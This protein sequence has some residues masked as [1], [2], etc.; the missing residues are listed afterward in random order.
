MAAVNQLCDRTIFMKHGGI[1]QIGTTSKIVSQYLNYNGISEAYVNLE[2]VKDNRTGNKKVEFKEIFLT[3]EDSPKYE[4]MFSV[5]NSMQINFSLKF[6]NPNEKKVKT[7]IELKTSEGMRL[8]NMIDVD[9]KFQV[10]FNGSDV[11][12]F[13]VVLKD[14]RLYPDTYY[15]SLFVGDMSSSEAYD[16]VEDCI[17]F[18]VIDGGLLTTRNLPRTAGLLF[19]TPEWKST[20]L[21]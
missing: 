15:L 10:E 14:I 5:G 20:Q 8:A 21:V 1:E 7:A 12:E 16:Y 18:E 9:S 6:R 2:N 19:L 4:R 3:R 11:A 17:S 13:K